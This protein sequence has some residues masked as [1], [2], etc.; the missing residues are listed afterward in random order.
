VLPLEDY[1]LK[2]RAVLEARNDLVVVARTDASGAGEIRRR[3]RAFEDAGADALLVDG[4][5]DLAFIAE[6]RQEFS[7]PL[8]FN[9][10]AGGK[11]PPRTLADLAGAGV[12][13]AIYSTPCLFAA[14]A[15]IEDAL[16]ALSASGGLL[17]T[18]DG[19]RSVGLGE[20]AAVLADNMARRADRSDPRP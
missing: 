3:L 16:E 6:L 11:A 14:Q 20:C 9:Q 8:A 10:I 19:G 13:L 7:L 17:E 5:R 15:G 2:L 18:G 12:S 1:I 4:I